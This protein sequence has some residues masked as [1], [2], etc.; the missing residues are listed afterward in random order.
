MESKKIKIKY[1]LNFWKTLPEYPTQEDVLYEIAYYLERDGRDNGDF[2]Q[3][4]LDFIFKNS[5]PDEL[6]EISSRLE[7]LKREK[8][9]VKSKETGE[10]KE[11]FKI[12]SNPFY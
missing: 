1:L 3:T 12:N 11:W 7:T 2:S 4:T 8:S 6:K 10:G 9:I 5:T